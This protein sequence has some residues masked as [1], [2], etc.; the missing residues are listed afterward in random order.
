QQAA[1]F[2]GW[3]ERP[4]RQLAS[5]LPAAVRGDLAGALGR[6]RVADVAQMIERLNDFSPGMIGGHALIAAPV[7]ERVY[8]AITLSHEMESSVPGLFFAG[9]SSSKI[10]GVT[11]GAVTG[12]IAARAALAR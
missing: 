7:V 6:R 9:D 12:R 3:R 10:I 2:L 5:S 1:D 8:P 4:T 11:Y